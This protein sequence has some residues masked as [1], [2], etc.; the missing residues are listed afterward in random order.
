MIN[1]W[2]NLPCNRHNNGTVWSF[3]DGHCEYWRWHGTIVNTPQ[4]QTEY[5]A[6]NGSDIPGDGS[7]DLPRT[8]AGSVPY[9]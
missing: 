3:A 4:Y 2:F 6:G 1:I 7:D 8:E 9:P 5:Y